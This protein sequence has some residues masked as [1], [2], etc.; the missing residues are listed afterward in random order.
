MSRGQLLTTLQE[1]SL[2]RRTD[3]LGT[4]RLPHG[5]RRYGKC[6]LRYSINTDMYLKEIEYLEHAYKSAHL[7]ELYTALINGQLKVP[8]EQLLRQYFDYMRLATRSMSWTGH[9]IVGY[10]QQEL[11]GTFKCDHE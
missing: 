5:S 11:G 2:T 9:H 3:S 8:M 7:P 4:T 6:K 1:Q 10:L